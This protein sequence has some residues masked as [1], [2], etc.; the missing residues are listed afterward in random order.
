MPVEPAGL[1]PLR[2]EQRLGL[3]AHHADDDARHR[4]CD[5]RDQGEL[6]GQPDHHPDDAEDGQHRV[7][8]GGERLLQGLLDVVHVIGGAGE[9][10]AALAGV[11]VAQRQPVDLRLDVLAQPEHDPHHQVV[12]HAPL[13]PHERLRHHIHGQDDQDQP[14]QLAEVDP[15]P[16]RERHAGQHVRGLALTLGSQ[17]LDHLLAAHPR[18]HLPGDEAA[19]DHVHRPSQDVRGPHVEHDGDQHH[20]RDHHQ[21]RALGPEQAQQPPGRGPERLGLPARSAAPLVRDAGLLE[22]G[23][24]GVRQLLAHAGSSSRTWESTICR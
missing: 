12:Q 2:G 8:E 3:L 17:A 20:Q 10:V 7:H 5:Q 13:Q 9:Q 24:L 6:P 23:E 14:P 11:E 1:P 15:L 22:L 18:G 21:A 19:E 4:Q 16:R